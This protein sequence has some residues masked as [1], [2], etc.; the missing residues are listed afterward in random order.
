MGC[1]ADDHQRDRAGSMIAVS[2]ADLRRLQSMVRTVERRA[3]IGFHRRE[4]VPFFGFGGSYVLPTDRKDLADGI[5]ILTRDDR[6]KLLWWD[7]LSATQNGIVVLPGDAA[8]GDRF[9][10]C[11]LPSETHDLRIRM[12]S[13]TQAI[14][15]PITGDVT[16]V[17]NIDGLVHGYWFDEFVTGTY[18]SEEIVLHIMPSAGQ[19][20]SWCM[21][22]YLGTPVQVQVD[23]GPTYQTHTLWS[24]MI[25]NN[26]MTTNAWW[27]QLPD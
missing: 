3:M 4:A 7:E 14:T 23:F 5:N 9:W 1:L 26:S 18:E 15:V 19:T 6:E 20:V 10:I 2:E 21:I 27:F 16:G 17:E 12:G 11:G 25:L 22:G 13:L 24:A 8:R